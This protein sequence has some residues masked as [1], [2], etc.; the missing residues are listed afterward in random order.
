M[1]KGSRHYR[2][3]IVCCAILE[4]GAGH[5]CHF[6]IGRERKNSDEGP[7]LGRL[8]DASPFSPMDLEE[9]SAALRRAAVRLKVAEFRRKHKL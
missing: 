2:V 4:E 9:A 3:G 8:E 5:G 1:K 7:E 6:E